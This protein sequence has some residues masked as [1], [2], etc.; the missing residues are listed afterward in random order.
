MINRRVAMKGYIRHAHM[1]KAK[2]FLSMLVIVLL[3][4]SMFNI[5]AL[6]NV[7][8]D[9]GAYSYVFGTAEEY[10]TFNKEFMRDGFYYSD[11]WFSEDPEKR[12]DG[13]ALMSMQLT[14]STVDDESDGSESGEAYLRKLGFDDIG[15]YGFHSEDPEDCAYMYGKKTVGGGTL[16]AVVIQSSAFDSNI[17]KKGWE[18]NFTLNGETASGEHYA[19]GRAADKVLDDIAALAGSE[20]DVKYWIMGHSRGGALANLISAKLPAE[21]EQSAGIF[22]YTFEA[23][24]VVDD[25][26]VSDADQYNYIHNYSCSDDIVTMVPP[27]EWGMTLYGNTYQLDTEGVDALLSDELKK[28]GSN[29]EYIEKSKRSKYTADAII[30]KLLTKIPSRAAYSEKVT[31]HFRTLD[32]RDVTIEYTP[33][34]TFTKL[35][36]VIFGEGLSIE[37]ITDRINEAYPAMEACIRGYLIEKEIMDGSAEDT[38]AYYYKAAEG[39]CDFLKPEDEEPPFTV[40]ELYA[41]LKIAAPVIIDPK[42]CN[43]I[44]SSKP[45]DSNDILAYYTP[46]V[47]IAIRSDEL[48]FSHHFDTVIARLK[49]LAPEPE[50]E[51][52]DLEI[53]YPAVGDK[54]LKT[55]KDIEKAISELDYAWLDASAKWDSDDTTIK[56]NKTYYLNVDYFVEGHSVPD[57]VSLILKTPD[58]NEPVDIRT[59]YKQGVTIIHCVYQFTLGTPKMYKVDFDD[60]ISVEP[61]DMTFPNGTIL[62]YVEQ[63]I[64][65]SVSGYIFKGWYTYKDELWDD[66]SVTE[67]LT[68][69]AKRVKSIE[70]VNISFTVPKVGQTWSMPYAPKNAPYHFEDVIVRDSDYNKFDKIT[71]KKEYTLDVKIV[72]NS[73]KYAFA[74][75]ENENYTGK[76]NVKGAKLDY[77]IT[78]YEMNINVS[79]VFTPLDNAKTALQKGGAYSAADKVIRASKSNKSLAGSALKPLRLKAAK[80]TRKSVKLAWKKAKGTKKYVVYGALKGKKFRKIT[81]VK[82]LKCVVK[83]AGTK[84]KS[85]KKYKFIVVAVDKN[86]KV[87]STSRTIIVRLK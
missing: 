68:F 6:Q 39:L 7:Y 43:V 55:P 21:L 56:G 69:C 44:P 36:G 14:A 33:Q 3:L 51:D 82:K 81:T 62:K 27:A 9:E 46:L 50:M 40:E 53:P 74:V 11:D 71:K 13:L 86:N 49:I 25:N 17:K 28:L 76:V 45:M 67:N 77:Y 30:Q 19:L 38:K 66:M 23:P 79:C 5:N 63:P 57:S 47:T 26:A 75:D 72:P 58:G 31:D 70:T 35:I 52:L 10:F 20:S 8:A 73:D 54:I 24:A 87:I 12:N 2:K 34:D 16:I 80:R 59:S 32:D 78:D 48:T 85:K 84:L 4:F 64:P 41:V 37:G 83:K 15:F 18:Q 60:E 42:Q 29:A 22:A 65:G 1:E 61:E